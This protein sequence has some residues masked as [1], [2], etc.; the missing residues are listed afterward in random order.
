MHSRISFSRFLIKL[1]AFVQSLPVL[2]MRPD[3]LVEFSRQ[4]YSKPDDVEGWAE[5][6]L[7][8]SGLGA[9]E[10]DLL[11]AMPD[12]TGNLLLLG[13]GGGREAITLSKMGFRVTGVDFVSAMV[14]RAKQN[15]ARRGVWFEGLVQE[16]SNLDVPINS[17]DVVWLSRSMYSCV[18]TRARRVEMV[19]RIDRSLKPGGFFLCQFHWDPKYHLTWKGRLV[20]RLI[21][22]C[23]LGNTAYDE[24]DILWGNIEF[25]HIFNSEAEIRS[26]LEDGGLSVLR[27]QT[28]P[29]SI[30]GGVVCRKSP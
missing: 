20:R 10:L 6:A 26:E 11:T 5:D 16:I 7:V 18:P 9:D 12:T 14:E 15:T 17:Y 22:A 29:N 27:I 13:V 1:G 23:T 3:D 21:A 24:G 25:L 30:R 8:D 2:V 19:R 28:N 4:S